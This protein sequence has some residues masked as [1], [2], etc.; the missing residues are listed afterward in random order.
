VLTSHQLHAVCNQRLL[1]NEIRFLRSCHKTFERQRIK[2]EKET[3][4]PDEQFWRIWTESSSL[5]TSI[6]KQWRL[7]HSKLSEIILREKYP[8]TWKN[9]EYWGS[10]R[11]GDEG[12]FG[13]K[14]RLPLGSGTSISEAVG[15][16]QSI[17]REF[18][19]SRGLNYSLSEL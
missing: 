18:V 7:G 8:Q 14:Y 13:A 19:I 4:E 1:D 10:E 16:A 11:S 5:Y 12:E 9:R 15:F 3:I 17:L 6:A 2:E